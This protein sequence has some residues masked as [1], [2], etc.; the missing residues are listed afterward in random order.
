[1]DVSKS[2]SVGSTI[3]LKSLKLKDV[4]TDTF[5]LA[6]RINAP[7]GIDDES[8]SIEIP[9]Q[10]WLFKTCVFAFLKSSK[11]VH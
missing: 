9:V 10:D 5:K 1:M 8:K 11:S 6:L 7:S 4:S 3:I 2:V